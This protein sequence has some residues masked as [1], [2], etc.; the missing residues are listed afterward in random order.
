VAWAQNEQG[1]S[2]SVST[3]FSTLITTWVALSSVAMYLCVA[4]AR[5]QSRSDNY[6]FLVAS[7]FLCDPDDAGACPAVVRSVDGDSYQMSG[8][9][10]FNT[11][12]NSATAAGTYTHQSSNGTVLET[13]VWIVSQLVSFDSY[14]IAPGALRVGGRPVGPSL[15]APKATGGLPTFGPKRLFMSNGPMPTGGLA[16]FRI[17]LLP[18]SGPSKSSVLQVNCA[19]GN[20]PSERSVEGIRLTSVGNGVEF[21][22]ELAGRVMFLSMRPE[23]SAPA[24]TSQPEAAPDSR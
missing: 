9:G 10:T 20:V 14:G 13:G 5:A 7:G 17:R 21:S 3:M 19:L 23:V 4:P 15:F 8:A 18:M 11:Q 1:F 12:S 6:T 22:E 16:V 2:G 24:K